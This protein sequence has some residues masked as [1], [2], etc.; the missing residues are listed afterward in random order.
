M[1]TSFV[2]WDLVKLT[3]GSKE[4]GGIQKTREAKIESGV[5]PDNKTAFKICNDLIVKSPIPIKAEVFRIER[6]L[7]VACYS[8]VNRLD[9]EQPTWK[10]GVVAT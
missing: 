4:S 6:G 1:R 3:E 8:I 5:V 10:K 7:V 9:G 2:V